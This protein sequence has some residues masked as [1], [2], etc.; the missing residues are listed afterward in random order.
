MRRRLT[1]LVLL[2]LA[3]SAAHAE[4]GPGP[5]QLRTDFTAYTR[6]RGRAAV[7]PL[8]LELGLI[9]E[10][11][12]GTYVPPWFA[13]T[14]TGAPAP[15]A[16]V[17]V[18]DWWSGPL[19]LAVRGGFLYMDGRGIAKLAGV[20]A[21][22]GVLALMGELDAS[23]VLTPQLCLSLG[24]DYARL[25]VTGTGTAAAS[26]IEG[27][28]VADAA[29]ARFFGQWQLTRAFGLTLLLRYLAYQGPIS[30]DMSAERN[31]AVV[32]AD[33]SGKSSDRPLRFAAVPGISLNWDHWELYAGI[34]YGAF[35]IPPLGLPTTRAWPIV[36]FAVAFHFDL[37]D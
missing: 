13:F 11:T 8:K 36:D 6:P 14:V 4:E 15:N 27:A 16:Y 35:L 26:S 23:L 29:T 2:V 25:T 12:L 28:S 1:S 30:A 34:G 32:D 5:A 31:G 3:P 37:Y 24:F 33:L 19:T 21:S 7:G 18:R 17:K 20:D 9:D 10:V 22:G